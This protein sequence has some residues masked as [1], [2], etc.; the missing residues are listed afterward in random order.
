MADG[1]LSY[2]AECCPRCYRRI[3]RLQRARLDRGYKSKP[4]DVSSVN[5][6]SVNWKGVVSRPAW[7]PKQDAKMLPRK[8]TQPSRSALKTAHAPPSLG[9]GALTRRHSFVSTP[10]AQTRRETLCTV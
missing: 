7:D 4:A 8:L 6:R 3:A 2:N 1:W 9:Q 5:G 10:G